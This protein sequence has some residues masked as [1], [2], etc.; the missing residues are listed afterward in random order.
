MI[1][2]WESIIRWNSFRRK[3]AFEI[4]NKQEIHDSFSI[5]ILSSP[6]SYD[7]FTSSCNFDLYSAM[8]LV[9][10]SFNVFNWFSQSSFSSAMIFVWFNFWLICDIWSSISFLLFAK[11]FHIITKRLSPRSR[12]RIGINKIIIYPS[13][14]G[15]IHRHCHILINMT[16]GILIAS[17]KNFIQN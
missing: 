17:L 1:S 6:W 14:E 7:F 4:N 11:F 2:K 3:I 15:R 10:A 5:K 12:I 13:L 9:F 16:P 8:I